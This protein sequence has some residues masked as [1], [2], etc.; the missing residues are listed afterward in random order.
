[1]NHR[2]PYKHEE[3]VVTSQDSRD[4][5]E[6]HIRQCL[7]CSMTKITMIEA[8]SSAHSRVWIARDGSEYMFE[9]SCR[10][11]ARVEGLAA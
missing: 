7:V 5:N 3:I 4:G 9:P 11:H 2:W 6:H 10:P 8:G 1:M